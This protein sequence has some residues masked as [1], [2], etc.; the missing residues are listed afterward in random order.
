MMGFR[1]ESIRSDFK[2]LD[3]GKLI[4]FDNACT[5]LR[6]EPVVNKILEY[7]RE[8]PACAGRSHHSLGRRTTEAVSSSRKSI[9]GFINAKKAEEI[10]F[11]KNTTEALN[12]V[13]HSLSLNRG[14]LILTT[15]KEHNSNLLPV[16]WLS[17]E[18]G[19]NHVVVPSSED[20]TFSLDNFRKL[21]EQNK[22]V[23]LVS[24]VGTSNMDGTSVPVK[25]ICKL[26]HDFGALL[27][28]DGAQMVPH[29]S[30]DVRK[31]GVDF[32]AFSS[33]KMMGP[34]GIGVLYGKEDLLENLPQF[35]MG[36]GTVYDSTYD[37]SSVEKVPH[38]F[39]GGIQDYP[40]II[41]LA[42]AAKYLSKLGF[43]NISSHELAINKRITDSLLPENKISLIGPKDPKL[44]GSIFSFNIVGKGPHE[45]AQ[46]LGESSNIAV[47]SGAHCVHSWF[48]AHNL[49][50]S[51]R[52]SF[53][54][55]NTLE[56]A[57]IFIDAIKS[58]IKHLS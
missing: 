31:L 28:I 20:G 36:G 45:V 14:D 7:Y 16:Q 26:T 6:P 1:A 32:L 27:M 53:Y 2:V 43:D 50:G 40:G 49:K 48:N 10:V 38:K 8:Y 42:E 46:I 47:R 13:Y 3:S 55:Y 18:K 39:E 29:H 22:N 15:D 19:I 54:A 35:I 11:T 30:V 21:L 4:Y 17:R 5:S 37:S 12:L 33:H 23:K 56:E 34:S 57:Q 51:V 25:D 58:I 24:M 41:G 44:R 52:A 9:Q